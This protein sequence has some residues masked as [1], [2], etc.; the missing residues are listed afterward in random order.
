MPSLLL[1]S[2]SS[3]LE[4][5]PKT[6]A[7]TMLRHE[8][9]FAHLREVIIKTIGDLPVYYVANPGN[10]G[11]AVS[12]QATL[13]FFS[14]TNI[15]FT[16]HT[17]GF[18]PDWASKCGDAILIYGGGGA[19]CRFWNHSADVLEQACKYFRQ[20]I[21]LPSTYDL[22]FTKS[23]A[24]FF[25]R[26]NGPSQQNQP[27][28]IFCH[29]M[30]FY[31]RIPAINHG[32]R[33][34]NYFRLDA[35]SAINMPLPPDSQDISNRGNHLSDI[36]D[37]VREI[38]E[39]SVVHTDRLHVAIVSCILCKEVHFYNGAY[40]KNQAVYISSIKDYFDNIRFYEKS[41]ALTHPGD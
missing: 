28:S 10:L 21:V 5:K 27:Q 26:D 17:E 2:G 38:G 3:N 25:R 41:A 30:A 7:T 16:E 24:I 14:D 20:V 13:K 9:E 1:K 8:P 15:T 39:C 22:S 33:T 31:L 40:F 29:D 18:S 34:G 32:P 23:N 11:D 35:E 6:L 19:W 12:R 37:F 4:Y 36:R